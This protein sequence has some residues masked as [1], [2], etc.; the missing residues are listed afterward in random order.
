MGP[1]GGD[2]GGRLVAMGTPEKIMSVEESH[3]G[4]W[5]KAVMRSAERVDHAL[6]AV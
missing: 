3:T 4:A 5:L 6:R 2:G 1:D